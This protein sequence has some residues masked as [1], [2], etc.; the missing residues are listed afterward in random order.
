MVSNKQV[1]GRQEPE[2]GEE[3]TLEVT[4][5]EVKFSKC[6][7]PTQSPPAQQC[8]TCG[9]YVC[10]PCDP[11]TDAA[12][13]PVCEG[14]FLGVEVAAPAAVSVFPSFRRLVFSLPDNAPFHPLCGVNF[15]NFD[16]MWT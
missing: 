6:E 10:P 13:C 11:A 14:S 1:R 9:V 15:P 2:E 7:K 3:A 4:I 5:V 12:V 16:N 8:Q